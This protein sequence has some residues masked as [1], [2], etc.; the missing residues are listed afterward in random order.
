M[1]SINRSDYWKDR[2]GTQGKGDYFRGPMIRYRE[3]RYW[4][5]SDC[6]GAPVKDD[7]K[8]N[9]EQAFVCEKCGE[10]CGLKE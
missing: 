5:R 1:A 10:F 3:G 4:Y 9:G 6:C 2:R 7:R 8:E